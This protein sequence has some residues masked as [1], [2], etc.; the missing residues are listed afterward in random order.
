MSSTRHWVLGE[1]ADSKALLEATAAL[2]AEQLGELDTHTPYPV[3]GLDEALGLQ[4]SAIGWVAFFG[5]L[6][7]AAGAYGMQL[8]FNAVQFPLNLGNR[9][10]HS[11]GPFVPV[12]FELMVLC[13]AFAIVGGLVVWFCRFPRPH[14]PV[15]EHED[16]VRTATSAGWWLSLNTLEEEAAAVAHSRLE[17]LGAQKIAVVREAP[18][19]MGDAW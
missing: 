4:R 8:W 19:E 14:H 12:T 18:E 1:F 5:G 10:P 17:A 13:S 6:V 11:P 15:F 9:P 7:G 16:F 3:P 2:R